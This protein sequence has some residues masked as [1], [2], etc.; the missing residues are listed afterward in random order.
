MA[1]DIFQGEDDLNDVANGTYI[2]MYGYGGDD[3]LQSYANPSGFVKLYGG[4]GG[5]YLYYYGAGKGNLKGQDGNDTLNGWNGDDKL[6][7]GKGSDWLFGGS[8]NDV[9]KGGKGSDH[10]GFNTTPNSKSNRDEI[11]DFDV[12]KDDLHFNLTVYDLDG[13]GVPGTISKGYFIKGKKA[14]DGD[15]FFGYNKQKGYVWYDENANDPGGLTKVV[16]I[17]PGLKLK[18][19]HFVLD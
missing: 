17:D 8:G 12:K 1:A 14:K 11:K 7:G 9:L 3:S 6:I 15:D 16:D 2:K 18:Y 10:F 5:D 4:D 19:H 13:L